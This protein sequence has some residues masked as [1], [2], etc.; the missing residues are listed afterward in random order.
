MIK[1]VF[2]KVQVDREDVVKVLKK[3]FTVKQDRLNNDPADG[4]IN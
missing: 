1:A 3:K 2:G 4:G